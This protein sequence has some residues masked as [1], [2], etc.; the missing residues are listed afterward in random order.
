MI[1]LIPLLV[2]TDVV[3]INSEALNIV[4]EWGVVVFQESGEVLCNGPWDLAADYSDYYEV[5]A[6][7]PVVW[8]HGAPFSGCFTVY[9]GEQNISFVYPEPARTNTGYVQWEISG[10]H[11]TTEREEEQVLYR[12]PFAWGID[13]WRAVPSLHLSHYN[14]RAEDN[15]LY[16]ECSVNRTFAELFLTRDEE[17]NPEFN[18]DLVTEGLMFQGNTQYLITVRNG[19]LIPL[20]M[21]V[22]PDLAA[23]TF[24]RWGNSR[25]KSSEISALWETWKPVLEDQDATWFVF[26]IPEEYHHLIS[27]I[28]LTTDLH[29]EVEYVRLFLGAVKL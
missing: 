20:N 26:P 14:T 23:E 15:F 16:Y 5:E 28:E 18:G 4:H 13:F 24:C 22:N 11:F 3:A 8:I 17:G 12:G 27:T 25:M 7:A 9:T 10:D 19:N 2:D 21:I 29:T 6:E 1:P